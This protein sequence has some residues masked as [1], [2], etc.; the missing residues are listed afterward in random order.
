MEKNK[1]ALVCV[2]DK[3]YLGYTKILLRSLK[4]SKNDFN[5]HI[6]L[7]NIS[8]K[9]SIKKSLE[10]INA[11]VNIKFLD[12]KFRRNWLKKAF[13]ANHR[14]EYINEILQYNYEG[15]IYADVDSIFRSPISKDKIISATSDIKIHFRDQNKTND[16]R[17]NIAAGIIFIRNSPNAKRFIEAWSENLKPRKLEWFADQILFY[18]TYEQHKSKINIEHLSNDFIDWEFKK[19][20]VIWAGKGTRKKYNFIYNLESL[21]LRFTNPIIQKI[22]SY[23]ENLYWVKYRL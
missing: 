13:C 11:D 1:I 7:I 3:K 20:S 15:I 2:A 18:K 17:F 12:K 9:V 19:N 10:R 23:L 22:I 16:D 6:C 8:R 14:A 4:K 5:I 21:K